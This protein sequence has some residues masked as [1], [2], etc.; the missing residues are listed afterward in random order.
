MNLQFIRYFV[1][2]AETKSF[3]KAAEKAFVVQSTFSSGIKKLEE[4]FGCSLFYRDKRNVELSVEG[5]LLLP[6]AKDLLA[7]WH[8][9]E[10]EMQHRDQGYVR[11]GIHNS[12]DVGMVLP[13]IKRFKKLYPHYHFVLEEC[14]EQQLFEKLDTGE[15]DGIFFEYPE[16]DEKKYAY[17]MISNDKLELVVPEDHPLASKKQVS[18]KA[19]DGQPFIDRCP[20]K[21]TEEIE[22]A[23]EE[24]NV[25]IDPVFVARNDDTVFSLIASGIGLSLLNKASDDRKGVSYIQL[26]DVE[27]RR[28]IVFIWRKGNQSVSLKNFL[29]I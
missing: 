26:S 3:T 18:I 19:L 12:L 25:K 13:E 16:I 9:M 8:S 11:F 22:R 28:E 6:K 23:F 2:L 5:E 29:N 20:C 1:L 21:I 10:Y 14:D 15:L 24:K 4:H 27:F 7:R 17:K